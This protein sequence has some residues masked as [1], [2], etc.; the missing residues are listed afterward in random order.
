MN[1]EPRRT[2]THRRVCR[3]GREVDAFARRRNAD[4]YRAGE[5]AGI[6]ADANRRDRTATRREL[7]GYTT[8]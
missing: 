8:I 3:G 7:R 6:K 2:G 5:R 1:T 4:G